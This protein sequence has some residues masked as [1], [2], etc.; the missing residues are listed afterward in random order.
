MPEIDGRYYSFTQPICLECFEARYP[1]R[2]A[3][4]LKEEIR[5]DEL[6]AVCG[7]DTREGIYFRHDPRD[8]EYPTPY[9]DE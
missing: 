8:L 1:N 4:R 5:S 6:C 2:V 9:D 7:V 3:S